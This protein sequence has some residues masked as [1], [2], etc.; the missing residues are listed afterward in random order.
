MHAAPVHPARPRRRTAHP[1]VVA[2]LAL[3]AVTGGCS[4][5][6]APAELGTESGQLVLVAH[7]VHRGMLAVRSRDPEATGQSV[8]DAFVEE[9]LI[10]D[11][12]ASTGDDGRV[13]LVVAIAMRALDD[14]GGYGEGM[15]GACMRTTATTGSADGAV[16]ERG[17]VTTEEVDCPDGLVPV[18]EG[19]E[20]RIVTG[21]PE[22]SDDVPLP[23]EDV[24]MTCYSGSGDC[25]G[26]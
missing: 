16:G 14:A 26:G 5:S 13:E 15:V 25:P 22:G 1:L 20:A 11:V 23:V 21:L 18:R 4:G 9:T 19:V 10:E 2:S 6:A 3:A 12:R 7:S 17:H 8:V 24:D